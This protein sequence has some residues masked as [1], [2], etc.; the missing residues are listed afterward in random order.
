MTTEVLPCS[1]MNIVDFEKTS[2]NLQGQKQKPP[3][4]Y[5][6]NAIGNTV[7]LAVIQRLQKWCFQLFWLTIVCVLGC[8][9]DLQAINNKHKTLQDVRRSIASASNS[10]KRSR[11]V[12]ELE[13]QVNNFLR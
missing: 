6:T 8:C 7:A 11:S 3:K 5:D 10:N 1:S 13:M 12:M 9:G 2:F 4:N